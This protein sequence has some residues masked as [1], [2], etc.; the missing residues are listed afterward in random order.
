MSIVGYN[1]LKQAVANNQYSTPASI[2]DALNDGVSETL[3]HGHDAAQAKDGMDLSF[4][5]ID[6]KK[7]EL[8]YA[9]AYNPLYLIRNGELIQTKADKFPIGLFLGEEKKKFTN[10]TIPLQKGD[11]IYIFSDGY[12]DQFGGP[13]GKK[14]MA[15]HFRDLLLDVHKHPI[16]KQRDILNKT[17]EEWRGPLDQV[18]DILIIGVQI[19]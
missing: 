15:S 11:C 10:H 8:Q 2:L 19:N 1:I 4:C 12:A 17:I 9:G 3:H 18:D 5:S 7:M 13:N 16:H 14:F 6:Y